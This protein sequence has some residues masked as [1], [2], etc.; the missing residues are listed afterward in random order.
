MILFLLGRGEYLRLLRVHYVT[1]V[2]GW[3]E[4]LIGHFEINANLA[5]FVLL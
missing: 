1:R 5:R 2:L 4:P 3:I